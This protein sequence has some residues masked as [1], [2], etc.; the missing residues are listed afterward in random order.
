M[1]YGTCELC[2]LFSYKECGIN[3]FSQPV[4][5]KIKERHRISFKKI[6]TRG[7]VYGFFREGRSGRERKRVCMGGGERGR[8]RNIDRLPPVSDLTGD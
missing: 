4:L 3:E 5:N 7:Y 1:F 6:L 8:E 2:I